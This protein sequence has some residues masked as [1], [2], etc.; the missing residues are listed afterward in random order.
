MTTFQIIT[1]IIGG[2][3][4]FTSLIGIASILVTLGKILER[5]RVHGEQ[6]AMYSMLQ[7]EIVDKQAEVDKQYLEKFDDTFSEISKIWNA[8]TEI[9]TILRYNNE[10]GKTAHVN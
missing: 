5:Q 7:K 1:L 8:I 2:L 3:G 10:D 4:G 6:I 9:K